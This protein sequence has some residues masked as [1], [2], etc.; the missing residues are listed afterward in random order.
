MGAILQPDQ[1]L[2]P[3]AV[4]TA[5]PSSGRRRGFF[6]EDDMKRI[7]AVIAVVAVAAAWTMGRATPAA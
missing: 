3:C 1:R 5:P 7:I 6:L 2:A 4:R